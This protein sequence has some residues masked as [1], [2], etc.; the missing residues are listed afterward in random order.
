MLLH[1]PRLGEHEIAA[2][3]RYRFHGFVHR[4]QIDGIVQ[5]EKIRLIMGVP[6]HLADDALLRFLV[7]RV[8]G[9]LIESAKFRKKGKVAARMLTRVHM[10]LHA[11]AGANDAATAASLHVGL[12]TVGRIRQRFV[13]AGLQAAVTKRRRP[14]GQRQLDG[15]Q[16][17]FLMALATAA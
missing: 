16:E 14:G 4:I 7:H 8:E 6:F 15:K 5:K 13:E 2:H 10:L 11:D 17:A 1:H 9:L 12:A 3:M